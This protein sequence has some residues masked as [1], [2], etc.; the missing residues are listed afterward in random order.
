LKKLQTERE[1]KHFQLVEI[2]N[3]LL[4][5]GAQGAG[6]AGTG[7]DSTTINFNDSSPET[8]GQDSTE[9][10]DKIFDALKGDSDDSSE[11]AEQE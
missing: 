3:R 7:S 9:S 11:G 4:N 6:D 10:F 2:Q 1:Q 8:A 5:L